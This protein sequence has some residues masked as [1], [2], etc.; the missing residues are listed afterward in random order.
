MSDTLT[1]VSDVAWPE[2]VERFMRQQQDI[3]SPAWTLQCSGKAPI[4]VY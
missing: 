1:R 3:V 4:D 2:P